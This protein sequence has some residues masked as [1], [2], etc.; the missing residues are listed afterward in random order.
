MVYYSNNSNINKIVGNN[1]RSMRLQ[2]NLT[3]E[4]MATA[5]DL[6]ISYILMIER[7]AANIS[8]KIAIAIAD[9]FEITVSQLYSKN[10]IKL[11]ASDKIAAVAK[12]YQENKINAKFFIHRKKEYSTAA[13]LKEVLIPENILDEY[14]VVGNIISVTLKEFE[15]ELSSQELSRELR[16]AFLKGY[17][18][19]FDK[20]GNKSTYEY[21]V[22]R[23]YNLITT[24]DILDKPLLWWQ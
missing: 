4:A 2:V 15:R 20:F 14:I 11:K 24:K 10:N 5:L 3:K 7:G 8:S 1:F 22:K 16:R 13:F 23:T 17:L 12:F 6:S 18:E 9:F 21:R 19:R